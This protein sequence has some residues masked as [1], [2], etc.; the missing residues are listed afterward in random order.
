M[1][2]NFHTVL[3]VIEEHL[4]PEVDAEE[5]DE[6]MELAEIDCQATRAVRAQVRK[7]A[8]T[9]NRRRSKSQ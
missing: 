3:C 9:Y 4:A 5:R 6:K 7:P 8:W 1:K 2:Y